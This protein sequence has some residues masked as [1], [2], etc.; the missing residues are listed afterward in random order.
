MTSKTSTSSNPVRLSSDCWRIADTC[1]V[2]VLQRGERAIA[3]DFGS[4][5]W[6]ARLPAMGIRHLDHVFLT[7][8]HTD[9]CRGLLAR[10]SWPFVIH[11]PAGEREFLSAEG[12][13]PLNAAPPGGCPP[14]YDRLRY[15]GL[16]GVCYDM[17][18]FSDQF[19]GSE[20]I[21]FLHTP[22]HGR[23]ACTVVADSQDGRQLAFCGD[24][25]HAHATIWQPYHLEWDHWTGE[26]ALAAWEGVQ[27]LSGIKV[28]LLCPSHGPAIATNPASTLRL[29]AR[30]LM[31]LYLVKGQISAGERDRYIK[32]EV[33]TAGVR[34][35]LPHLF[36]FGSNGYLLLSDAGTAFVIDPFLDDMPALDELMRRLPGVRILATAATHYHWDHLDAAPLLRKRHGARFWLHPSLAEALSCRHWRPWLKPIPIIPDCLWPD[37]GTWK[38]ED[39]AFRIAHWPGQTWWHC[40]FMTEVDGRRVMFGGDS[41]QPPSRWN[42]TGGF[43]AANGSRF[44]ARGFAGSARLAIRWRPDILACGHATYCRFSSSRFR[45]I[46]RWAARAEAALKALCPDGDLRRHYYAATEFSD[47]PQAR[48][49]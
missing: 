5:R 36:Q 28:D 6:L 42:G 13:K 25:V 9:Q 14:S 19:W 23:H 35:I 8:H 3:V 11:A 18:G 7:H 33:L 48:S 47:W 31:A 41:F 44:G 30:R 38:W 12:V 37:Q 29:T 2:Y 10:K 39:Y 26:G 20:R 46:E 16:G 1:N 27:R 22:G 45:K 40:V 17:A 24:A 15:G 4:G 32:P 43:C 21:R 34:R 49:R